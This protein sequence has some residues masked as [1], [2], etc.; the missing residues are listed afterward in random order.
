MFKYALDAH[1]R[2]KGVVIVA[3]HG[4]RQL[5]QRQAELKRAQLM[6]ICDLY[7]RLRVPAGRFHGSQQALL[8]PQKVASGAGAVFR[9]AAHLRH[10]ADLLPRVERERFELQPAGAH[11]LKLLLHRAAGCRAGGQA[12]DLRGVPK[13]QRL[14]RGVEHRGAFAR[15]GGHNGIQ[16]PAPE[17]RGIHLSC[18]LPLAAPVGGV[19]KGESFNALIAAGAVALHALVPDEVFVEQFKKER[20]QLT[21]AID[22]LKLRH[23]L[24]V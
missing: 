9:V 15:A 1:A 13:P 3:D 22:T 17:D 4:V 20:L 16:P 8:L 2:V 14:E 18:H 21:D 7:H 23:Q 10:G 5:A 24:P 12:I 19:G 11:A 6:P